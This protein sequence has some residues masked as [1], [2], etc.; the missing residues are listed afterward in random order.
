MLSWF[1]SLGLGARIITTTLVILVAVVAVNYV[2]FVGKYKNSAQEAM[3]ERAAAFTAVADEAKNHVADLNNEGTFDTANLLEDLK[4]DLASGKSY[5]ES[6]V[7]GTIPVVAG[8]TAAQAAADRENIDFRVSAYDA[9][10]KENE[11]SRDSFGGKLLTDLTSQ[12]KAGGEEV[13]YGID[14]ATNSLHYLRAI[15]LGQECMLCHGDPATSPTGDGKDIL[16]FT[17]ENWKP[18]YMHGAYHVVLPLEPM[19]QNVASF[20]IGGLEWTA[21]IVIGAVIL[22]VFLLRTMFG[23][24]VAALI[25]RIREI[26]TENDL[27]KRV[28]VKGKDEVGQLGAC[29][30]SFV[31]TLQGVIGNVAG[32]THEVAGAATEIAASSEEIASG[33]QEQSSQITQ[34]SSAVEEMSASIVEVARKSGEAAND[35]NESGK[36]AE[37]GGNVVRETI[38]G[39]NSIAEA[40]KAGAASVSELGKR[41]EQIGQIIEVINDI[42]DQTN[43]LA[44]NAAIEAARAGEHG[45]GFAVVADEV[46]KLAD[47]TTKATEE[48]AQ[49]IQAIQSETGE[50]VAK[51]NAG[52]EQVTVGVEKATE[53]GQSLEKIVAGARSVATNVQSIAAA[54]EQQSAAA[55]EVSRNIESITAV[56]AQSTEGAQQA[57]QAAT[58]LSGKAEELLA[59]VSKFKI[60]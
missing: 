46:R 6:R 22:F 13:I 31:E 56:T 45:R 4:K 60:K 32:S 27:T 1:K 25:A 14:E 5:S 30:N 28:D 3:V 10:N 48:I 44:L 26:Q 11:P 17:M 24:P 7:F 42:A 33:M 38:T 53:A 12:V 15:T 8:W 39:M 41:G 57:A 40:V 43:L 29:F 37:D 55:E 21:P 49:S 19:D 47:R 54:A 50:A 51:M 59:L 20:I 23:K 34:I 16:G 35:A 36:V 9:R 2:V 58:Q 18:G 52:T